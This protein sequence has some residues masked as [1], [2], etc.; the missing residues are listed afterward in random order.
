MQSIMARAATAA[1]LAFA[2]GAGASAQDASGT[3]GGAYA[4]SEVDGGGEGEAFIIS[5]SYFTGLGGLN[6]QLDG[7]VF[8]PDEDDADETLAGEV[9]LFV[10]SETTAFGGF[11]S[12]VD[13][14]SS[15]TELGIG[16]EGEFYNGNWTFGGVAGIFDDDVGD[17]LKGVCGF[18]R[19]YGSDSFS[20]QGRIGLVDD[21]GADEATL[22]GADAEYMFAGSGFSI[23]GSA[24][25]LE[26]GA[27]ER[28]TFL[29]GAKYHF[30]QT[31]L[32]GRDRSGA[33][34][35]G[36]QCIRSEATF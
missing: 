3:I 22:F 5:G 14:D 31:S 11:G 4:S 7:D 23:K 15:E 1:T 35:I 16:G 10:R 2:L 26:D 24:G 29:F 18:G 6:L 19:L 8:I 34:M 25:Q 21:G 33:G 30:G 32:I 28:T 13:N 12:I 20:L 9:H 17:E 36:P 27:F